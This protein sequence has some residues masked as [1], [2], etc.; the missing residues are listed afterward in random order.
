VRLEHERER[1]ARELTALQASVT[2]RQQAL[3]DIEAQIVSATAECDR[4]REGLGILDQQGAERY[5]ALVASEALERFL[6]LH[7]TVNDPFWA[8]LESL[9]KLKRSQPPFGPT[10]ADW[11]TADLRRHVRAFL[12][13]LAANDG[14]N[15]A[16][17]DTV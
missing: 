9:F 12:E 16:G 2:E 13:Q 4:L 5:D 6:L 14:D 3:A 7:T 17:S 8:K 15:R 1:A 10:H 11:L